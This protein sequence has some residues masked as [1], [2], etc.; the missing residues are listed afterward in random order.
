MAAHQTS[1]FQGQGSP[2]YQALPSPIL[3][4]HAAVAGACHGLAMA[5]HHAVPMVVAAIKVPTPH[6]VA[7]VSTPQV[8][9]SVWKITRKVYRYIQT[10][11]SVVQQIAYSCPADGCDIELPELSQISRHVQEAHDV[12]LE[13][14]KSPDFKKGSFQIRRVQ[15][16]NG[17]HR[18]ICPYCIIQFLVS[19]GQVLLQH[20]AEEHGKVCSSSGGELQGQSDHM[21]MLYK[22]PS[23]TWFTRRTQALQRLRV[24]SLGSFCS[25]KMSIQKV[26]L[27]E[28]HL[29]FDWVRSSLK[30]IRHFVGNGFDGF[31]SVA[32]KHI[33][34]VSNLT[35]YRS[36]YVSFWHDDITQQQ[37]RQKLERRIERF[38]AL[39]DDPRELLFLRSAATTDELS[40]MEAVHAVLAAKFGRRSDG[41]P[42]RVM[43]GLVLD[44]QA[45]FAGPFLNRRCPDIAIITYPVNGDTQAG[46]TFCDAVGAF[47]EWG[48]ADGEGQSADR[49]SLEQEAQASWSESQQGHVAFACGGKDV[50]ITVCD[51]GL[52]TGFGDLLCFEAPGAQHFDFSTGMQAVV[53]PSPPEL[54][55]SSAGGIAL[56]GESV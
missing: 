51:V 56:V 33:V 13:P 32:T 4:S 2:V 29:P 43:L 23:S 41:T 1:T 14:E 3:L 15:L 37:A 47:V 46:P 18:I 54:C 38:F 30:G 25:M 12:S 35:M 8:P 6:G 16:T 36:E 39:Q 21:D 49:S 44:G 17:E 5:C 11:G 26:G 34:P 7:I 27:A 48:L 22:A 53:L 28:E 20:V 19:E 52:K 50:K 40:E 10:D 45:A 31:F 55:A 24:V 42:R 9:Q